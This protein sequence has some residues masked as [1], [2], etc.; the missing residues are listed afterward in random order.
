MGVGSVLTPWAPGIKL[1]LLGFALR[2]GNKHLS[3][4]HLAS[5]ACLLKQGSNFALDLAAVNL[6]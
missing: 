4:I 5:P 2:L 6:L 1:K 3:L